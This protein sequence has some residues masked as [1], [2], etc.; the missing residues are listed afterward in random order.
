MGIYYDWVDDRKIIM[1]FAIEQPWS[2][3]EYL[4]ILDP[5]MDQLRAHGAPCATVVDI[6]KMGALPRDG[7]V[8]QILL[9]V[10]KKMPPNVF[11]S[12]MVGAPA[13]VVAFMNVVTKLRPNAKRLVSFTN[14]PEEAHEKIYTRFE[15]LYPDK[16]DLLKFS[17]EDTNG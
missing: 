8:I 10:D 1:Q 13:V 12:S 16:L 5:A 6:R 11:A 4:T 14:T 3:A 17:G 2:W 9:L 15:K 7:N